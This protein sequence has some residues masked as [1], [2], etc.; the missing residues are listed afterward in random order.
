MQAVLEYTETG[1]QPG[2]CIGPYRLIKQLEQGGMSTVFLG[3]HIDTRGFV[4][5]K[6]VDGY[7]ANL[8]MLYREIEIMQAL[9]HEHIVRCLDAG[10]DGRYHYLCMPYLQGGTL[11]DKLN[12]G[13]P[14]LEEACIILEQLA[15]ALAYIH[16]LG[17]LHRD[18][19]PVNILFD[20]ANKLYL[21]DFG[22]VSWLGEKPGYD[23]H[24]MGTPHYVAPEIFE[25][26]MDVRSEVYSVGILLYQMLTGYV[27]FDGTSD[28]ICLHHWNSQPMAPSLLNP[29][30]PRSVE[31]VILHALEKDPHDRYQTVEDLLCAFQKALPAPTYSERL[32]LNW[33]IKYQNNQ[34]LAI[35]YK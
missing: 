27:P 19:K 10:Q 22:I 33:L 8:T 3:Y 9:E 7:S 17:L 26:Y 13:L 14:T 5:I 32:S 35:G 28:K 4:A 30:L 1:L 34:V 29:S 23:G 16:S 24:M 15:S 12:E 2:T 20:Q 21:T 31:R 18:I 11:E 25:G 6:V